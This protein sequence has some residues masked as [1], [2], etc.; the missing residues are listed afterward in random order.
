MAVGEMVHLSETSIEC[1]RA[2]EALT[3]CVRVRERISHSRTAIEVFVFSQINE[4][5]EKVRI[6]V[7]VGTQWQPRNAVTHSGHCR[8][9]VVIFLSQLSS[10]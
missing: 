1:T 5:A 4:S 7:A 3:R 8:D 9:D 6:C 2:N 10:H